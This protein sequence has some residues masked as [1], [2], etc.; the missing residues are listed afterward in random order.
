MPT[1]VMVTGARGLLGQHLMRELLASGKAVRAFVRRCEDR[2]LL[3]RGVEMTLGDVTNPSDVRRAMTGCDSVIHA[4]S[5]HIYNLPSNRV[6]DVNVGGARNVCN[7]ACELQCRRLVLTST[8]STLAASDGSVDAPPVGA[9]ARKLMSLSKRAAEEE[10]LARARQGLPAVVV[11]PPYFVG[12]Y[13]Y[14]PSPFR[15]WAPLAAR[16]PI[17][18]VP[19]GGFNVMGARDVSRAHVWALDYGNIGTRYPIVGRNISLVEYAALLNSAAGQHVVPREIPPG[20]LRSLAVGKVF[21]RYT[22][23]LMTRANYVFEHDAI[24]IERESLED[25][26]SSTVRWFRE[27]GHL[28]DVWTLVR[29]AWSRY[30]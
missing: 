10:V 16:M 4:C 25:V 1:T 27:D 9:P 29:Y 24:P 28:T 18:F 12:P 6:W 20:L 15:L 26:V 21:D 30:F 2:A 22:V 8:I 19:G 7:A 13:D 11:N 5:T 3:P 14:S 17:R 23:A